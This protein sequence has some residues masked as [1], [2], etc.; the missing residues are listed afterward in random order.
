VGTCWLCDVTLTIQLE[1][2]VDLVLRAQVE[3]SNERQRLRHRLRTLSEGCDELRDSRGI[4]LTRSKHISRGENGQGR[5]CAALPLP[6]S[7]ARALRG[8]EPHIHAVVV[9]RRERYIPVQ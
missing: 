1:E 6:A 5:P 3:S 7:F 2:G 9:R 4:R 8:A